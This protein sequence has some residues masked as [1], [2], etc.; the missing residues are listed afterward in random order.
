MTVRYTYS[1]IAAAIALG[2]FF[3]SPASAQSSSS[4]TIG[5]SLVVQ[6]AC[7]VNGANS[8]QS[9]V[10]SIGNIAFADQPGIFGDVDG[11]LVG[12]LGA[13]QVL[14]SPGVLPELTI[15]SGDNAAS[16][17]RYMASAGNSLPYRL[18]TDA[19]RANEIGIGQR[20]SLGTATT[21]PIIVPIFAR[22]NSGG[23][24]VAAGTY[25][26]TVLV[27]LSW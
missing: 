22:V 10:G 20:L 15:G 27:T 24:V 5:V 18:Y 16:G 8:V 25:T 11:E 6:N 2:G 12:S 14:C 1:G 9:N 17:T 13:L 3:L 21:D 19:Q 26:D 23:N 4:G 7:V